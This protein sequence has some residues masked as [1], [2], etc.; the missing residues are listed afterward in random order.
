MA[1]NLIS[2]QLAALAKNPIAG[3]SA[4]PVE[5]DFFNLNVT[6]LGPPD[7]PYEGGVFRLAIRIPAEYPSKPPAVVFTTKI[8]HP[9]INAEYVVLPLLHHEQ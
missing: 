9:N 4:S 8:Y 6:L 5:D 1:V 3:V 2:R 7:S